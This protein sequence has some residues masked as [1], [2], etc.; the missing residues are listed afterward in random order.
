MLDAIRRFRPSYWLELPRK[1]RDAGVLGLNERN[2]EYVLAHN[3][4]RFYPLVDD[5]EQTKRLAVR[6]GLAVPDL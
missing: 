3:P 5:K 6:A 4:R 1:L 2:A